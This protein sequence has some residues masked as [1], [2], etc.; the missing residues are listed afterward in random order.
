MPTQYILNQKNEDA[1]EVHAFNFVSKDFTI[2][3]D[4]TYSGIIAFFL[5]IAPLFRGSTIFEKTHVI[6]NI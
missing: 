2:L 1:I 6:S 5:Y 3:L 4:I